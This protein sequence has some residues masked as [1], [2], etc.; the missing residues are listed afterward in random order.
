[1]NIKDAAQEFYDHSIHIRGYAKETVRRYRHAINYYCSLTGHTT[2]EQITEL[3]V[4][5]M[6]YEGRQKRNWKPMTFLSYQ[7]SLSV[8][9][10]W[11]QNR[12]Y[13]KDNPIATLESPK[14]E[15]RLPVNLNKQ[16]AKKL[17]EWVY[18]YP[19]DSSFIRYRNHAIFAA[20]LYAGL[21]K[22]EI[23]Q[24]RYTDVDLENMTLFINQ[25]KG[26]KDRM[27]PISSALAGSLGRYVIERRTKG[28]T[29][30]SFFAS[31]VQNR[32]ISDTTLKR[33]IEAMRKDSGIKF[34][35]YKLRHTFAT[36]MLEGGCDIYS[37]S[38]MMGHEDIKTTTIYLCATTEHLRSQMVKHPLNG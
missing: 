35:A 36:L 13:M 1:M 38:K 10:K 8:F 2:L 21:R 7:K 24:L 37:L 20:L 31:S 17:L 32:G 6:F 25:S 4:R 3:S 33:L 28:V 12:K 9:F 16:D 34:S 18:N 23:L 27:I 19:Y 14:L 15:R 11:C 5:Q 26:N 29:C 22:Q 30:P